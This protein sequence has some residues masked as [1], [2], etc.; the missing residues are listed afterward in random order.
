MKMTTINTLASSVFFLGG[1]IGSV[2]CLVWLIITNNVFINWLKDFN[3]PK[4][5]TGQKLEL[6]ELKLHELGGKYLESCR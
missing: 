4:I 1:L 5:C 3:K 6:K 2:C